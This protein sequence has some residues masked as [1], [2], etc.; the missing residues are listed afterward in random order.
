LDG[1][2]HHRTHQ[3]IGG[4]LVPADRFYGRADRVLE[5]IQAHHAGKGNGPVPATLEVSEENRE[6]S[7]FQI[8]LVGDNLELWLFGRRVGRVKSGDTAA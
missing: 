7:L 2:N 5:R 3:G 6:V 4:V 8:R 1:F